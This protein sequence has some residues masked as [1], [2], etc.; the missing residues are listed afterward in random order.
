MNE[1]PLVTVNILSFNRKDELRNTLTKVFEQDYKNIEV[2]VVDN[3][4]N[5]GS[6]EMVKNEFPS[7]Q[8][9]QM[10][11]NIGIA[12][13]NEGFK[14]AKGEYVLVLDD[15][16]Y[17]I[18]DSIFNATQKMNT[19]P[20]IGVLACKVVQNNLEKKIEVSDQEVE[21]NST[22]FIGCGAFIKAMV[23][24]KI[25]YF[26]KSL[27]IYMHE[28]EYAMRVINCGWEVIFYPGSIVIHNNSHLNRKIDSN[29]LDDRKIF[30]DVRNLF[31]IIFLHF[32]ISTIVVKVPRIIFGRVLFGIIY[33][34]LK[35]VL[36]AIYSV[37]VLSIQFNFN[38]NILSK[39]T[40]KLYKYG[41]FAGGF[42]FFNSN[43]GLNR[44]KWLKLN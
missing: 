4:S 42:F 22:S 8:L 20:S 6:S 2:I 36:S 13:W 27:F 39:K 43:Y 10:E 12:G 31:I 21:R 16:S 37:L 25:G 23:I 18:K 9:I 17:P 38:R 15:D 26:E 30:Y 33:G 44:P 29:H 24:K 19:T 41:S 11:K 32:P 3:A 40:Q 35:V 14:A 28:V 34:K 5:D 1:Q 7:V